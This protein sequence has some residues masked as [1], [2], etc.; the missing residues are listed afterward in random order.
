MTAP[1]KEREMSRAAPVEVRVCSQVPES[2]RV[3]WWC[4]VTVAIER[5]RREREESGLVDWDDVA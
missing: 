5:D 1:D 3:R 2:V 4:W